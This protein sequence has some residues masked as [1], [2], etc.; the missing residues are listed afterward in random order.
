KGY[1]VLDVGT[2]DEASVDYP[3]Y[4]AKVGHLVADGEY[5]K[6]VLVCGSGLGVTI[7]ANKIGGVRAV[8]AN[9]VESAKLGRAHNNANVLGMGARLI[10][11]ELAS[12]VL[13]EWL[14]TEFLGGRHERRLEKITLIEGEERR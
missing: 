3:D 12:R 5:P 2:Y 1:D 11:S 10:D 9:D 7:A 4:A 8:T 13:D 6:G 14:K